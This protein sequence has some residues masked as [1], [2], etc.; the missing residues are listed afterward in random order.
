MCSSSGDGGLAHV[1]RKISNGNGESNRY[2][3]EVSLT[4]ERAAGD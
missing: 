1:T 4:V 2:L 3:V